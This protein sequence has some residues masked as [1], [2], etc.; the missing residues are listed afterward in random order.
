[1]LLEVEEGKAVVERGVCA[2]RQ[3]QL[4]RL[5]K[6]IRGDQFSTG[7]LGNTTV[8]AGQRLCGLLVLQVSEILDRII[9]VI[10]DKNDLGNDVRVREVELFWRSSVM[11][12]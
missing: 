11:P 1:M 4:D 9:L 8:I 2:T 10:D 5:I 12:T 3:N 7:F 6:A